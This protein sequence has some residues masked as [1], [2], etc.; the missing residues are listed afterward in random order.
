MQREIVAPTYKITDIGIQFTGHLSFDEWMQLGELIARERK[1]WQW[2]LATW[3]QE[4]EYRFGE[5]YAAAIDLTQYSLR[6]LQDYVYVARNVPFEVRSERLSFTHHK[7]IASLDPDDQRRFLAD[8]IAGDWTAEDLRQAVNRFKA[9][10]RGETYQPY[11]PQLAVRVRLGQ[12]K[13]VGG[14]LTIE[15][16]DG[17]YAVYVEKLGDV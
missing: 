8:A 11:P 10:L 7:M 3:V 9:E 4:G 15:L 2:A 14:K 17:D 6:T 12:F 16:E 13:A 1:K 5:M